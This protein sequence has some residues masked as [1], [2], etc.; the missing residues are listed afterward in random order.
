MDALGDIHYARNEHEEA[1][2]WFT[3]GAEAGLPKAMYNLGCRLDKGEG[4]AAADSTAAADW[5][6]R[7][8][9]AGVGSAAINLANMYALGRGRAWLIVPASSL[10]F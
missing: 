10:D 5:Y 7:A 8:A 1:V 2:K 6:M 9:D 4:V 3:K